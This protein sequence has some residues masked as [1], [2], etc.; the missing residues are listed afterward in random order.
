VLTVV[1]VFSSVMG[2]F[3]V[4]RNFHK[5]NNKQSDAPISTIVGAMLG[6]LAFILAF[7][8]GMAASRLDARKQLLMDE[9]NAIGTAFLR[10]DFLPAAQRDETKQLF[11]KYVEVRVGLIGHPEKLRE[12]LL[13][14]DALQDKLWSQVINLP[15]KAYSPALLALYISSLNEVIDIHEKRVIV[16]TQYRIPGSIILV[17]Y[18]LTIL[19]MGMVGYDFGVNNRSAVLNAVVVAL[20]FAAILLLIEDLDRPSEG[21][22]KVNQKPMF[23][24]QQKLNRA[25]K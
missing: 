9:T 18:F 22:L 15:E 3:H 6:L 12:T 7:T 1:I 21:F 19:A 5:N 10:A 25:E 8:F 11:K 24:L 13:E 2:G 14:S 4:G 20:A 23:D 16:G 17:L